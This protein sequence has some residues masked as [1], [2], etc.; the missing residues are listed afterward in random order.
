MKYYKA[1]PDL[2]SY[3][4]TAGVIILFLAIGFIPSNLTGSK[5]G[6]SQ[7][8]IIWILI[9]ILNGSILLF[10]YLFH[11]TGYELTAE[12]LIIRRPA[13]KR[14]ISFSE[15]RQIKSVPREEL[16]WSVRTL[17]NGGVFGYFGKFFNNSFGSMTWYASRR[18]HFVMIILNEGEKV[19]VTPDDL[20]FE[21]EVLKY[22]H[23][24]THSKI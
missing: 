18:D 19:V 21:G 17:G 15:I 4:I 6:A 2:L 3:G 7:I 24:Q 5:F 1:T 16:K 12:S 11:V 9:N 10:C 20:S 13:K 14:R 23:P 22:I 8:S